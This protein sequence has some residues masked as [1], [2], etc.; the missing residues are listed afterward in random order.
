MTVLYTKDNIKIFVVYG[1]AVKP[2]VKSTRKAR[3]VWFRTEESKWHL[4]N[5]SKQDTIN[6]IMVSNY[7]EA[8]SVL[9]HR[10]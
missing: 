1:N 10:T 2:N 6:T 9:C 8:V 3:R 7:S 4:S 5:C